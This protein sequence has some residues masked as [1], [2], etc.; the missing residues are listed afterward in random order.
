V[1]LDAAS[2]VC[3]SSLYERDARF[4]RIRLNEQFHPKAHGGG[5]LAENSGSW[6]NWSFLPGRAAKD[7]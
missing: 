4:S 1:N 7:R 3:Q 6:E 5:V 2:N